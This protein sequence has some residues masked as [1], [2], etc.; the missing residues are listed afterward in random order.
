MTKDEDKRV[1]EEEQYPSLEEQPDH[2]G[3]VPLAKVF[4]RAD[5]LFAKTYFLLAYDFSSNIYV[6]GG[7]DYVTIV[8][9][10]NDYTGL[11]DLFNLDF[12]PDDIKKI[13]I[14]HGHRDHTMGALEL[15]RAYP[16]VTEGGGFELILHEASPRPFKDIVRELNCRVTEVRGGESLQLSGFEWEVIHT[17]GHTVD[18]ICLYHAP[19]KT[20]F[21]GDTVLPYGISEPDKNAG[22]SLDSYLYGVKA[23]LKKDIENLLPGHGVPVASAGKR[24]IEVAYEEVMVKILGVEGQ[25]PWIAGATALAQKGLLEEA[26]FCCDKELAQR[27]ENPKALHLKALCLNDLGRCDEALEILDKILERRSDDL[28]A[29]VGKGHAL[30]G[31]AKYDE[32]LKYLDAALAIRPNMKDVQVFKGMALYLSGRYD[33]AMDIEAFKTE[34][35]G[36]FKEELSTIKDSGKPDSGEQ[37]S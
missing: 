10:G 27:S 4:Q 33:D 21:T 18:G 24:V 32:S 36:K 7:D 6:V 22:G 8:D 13:V 25:T 30:L 31:L 11:M 12:K 37:S 35:M 1:S 20:A 16:S 26:L 15:L 3:W 14:T 23:L 17:P 28:A 34:F 29:L 2:P 19:T 9:P 5:S